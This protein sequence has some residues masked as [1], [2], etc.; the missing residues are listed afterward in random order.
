VYILFIALKSPEEFFSSDVLA[1][2]KILAWSNFTEAGKVLLPY[3]NN[4]VKLVIISLPILLLVSS[5]AAYPLARMNFRMR[6]ML[7]GF[8]LFGMM[9]PIS[10]TIIPLYILFKSLHL[11]NTH[12]SLVLSYIAFGIPFTIFMMRG[13]FLSIPKEVEESAK[14]DGCSPLGI[15]ARVILPISTPILT[16]AAVMNFIGIWNDF[17]FAYTFIQDNSKMT[18][19]VGLL[20]FVQQFVS[21]MN[22]MTAGMI[23]IILPT[24]I[25]FL[26]FQKYIIVRTNDGSV[27]G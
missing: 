18:L 19:N 3:F 9:V 4:N 7:T 10:I 27:K 17:F 1:F 20:A 23:L 8:F 6:E 26:V 22:A 14:I 5:L 12:T 24:F 21:K 15:Y 16:T 25:L 2:P 11:L 13:Y